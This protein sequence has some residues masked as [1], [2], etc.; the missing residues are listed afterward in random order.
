[1]LCAVETRMRRIARRPNDPFPIEQHDA[2]CETHGVVSAGWPTDAAAQLAAEQHQATAPHTDGGDDLAEYHA[3]L[4]DPIHPI[5][6]A[7][8]QYYA[9]V[10]DVADRLD[11]A[12]AE[13]RGV[14]F[15][16]LLGWVAVVLIVV[17][18]FVALAVVT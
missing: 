2:V 1:M 18:L 10:G 8:G 4:P 11:E 7:E 17:G 3:R 6:D 13:F 5:P 15:H 9:R 14:N 16:A 12:Y